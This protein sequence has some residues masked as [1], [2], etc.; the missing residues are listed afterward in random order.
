MT[1]KEHTTF[2]LMLVIFVC[3]GFT[4]LLNESIM[5]VA[6]PV[7][8]TTFAVPVTTIQWLTTGFLL[9][10]GICIPMTAYILK[11]FPLR[12]VFFFAVTVFILGTVIGGSATNF[13]M[14]ISG[15]LIQAIGTAC[16]VPMIMNVILLKA[17]QN[18]I[19]LYIGFVNLLLMAAP[20]LGPVLSGYLVEWLNWRWLFFI[21][22]PVPLISLVCGYILLQNVIEN[23]NPKLDVASVMLTVIAFGG[24]IFGVG[25]AGDYGFTAPI[26]YVPLLIGLVGLVFFIRR[27]LQLSEPF[28]DLRVM[29]VPR[30]R[31]GIG[32]AITAAFTLFGWILTL[33][34]YV[35]VA[36]DYSTIT[37]GMILLPGGLVN[38]AMALVAGRMYDRFG[39]RFAFLGFF[40]AGCAFLVF[41]AGTFWSMPLWGFVAIN[42]LFN[43]GLPMAMTPCNTFALTSLSPASYPHGTAFSSTLFQIFGALGTAIFVTIIYAV[44]STPWQPTATE[45][46]AFI[47]GV[48]TA[49]ICGSVIL[50][51]LSATTFIKGKRYKKTADIMID[52]KSAA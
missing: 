18:K 25:N 48:Q 29:A 16:F 19:G 20:A 46:D 15:R 38:C 33:P 4:T 27:Q 49:L 3:V 23:T 47:G 17:P 45:A 14:L 24:I 39:I 12:K 41:L 26:V 6:F 1:P 43:F 30:Y 28:L 42:I 8:A 52:T 2:I 51:A 5:N 9:V 44:Q 22:L 10:M 11:K 40:L 7:L 50:L 35:Q 34:L 21:L 36:L 37:A 13:V 32:L 31:L